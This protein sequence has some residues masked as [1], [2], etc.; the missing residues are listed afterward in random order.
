MNR[1]AKGLLTTAAVIVG[2]LM[3]FWLAGGTTRGNSPD[4]GGCVV[5]VNC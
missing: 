4:Q 5:G 3:F 2:L 1:V